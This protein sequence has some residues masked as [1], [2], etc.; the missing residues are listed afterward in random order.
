[1]MIGVSREPGSQ[2]LVIRVSAFLSPEDVAAFAAQERAAV[3]ALGWQS[4]QYDLL[5]DAA[6]ATIQSQAVVRCFHDLVAG[7]QIKARRIAV[8]GLGSLGRLQAQ[9]I[10]DGRD[11]VGLFASRQEAEAWLSDD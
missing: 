4:G 3:S 10:F 6:A 11:G 9:R 2:R 8:A 1:M 5:V 7:A